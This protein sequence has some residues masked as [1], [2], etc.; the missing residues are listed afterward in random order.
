MPVRKECYDS[1]P[2]D[3]QGKQ[4]GMECGFSYYTSL[5]DGLCSTSSSRRQGG[6]PFLKST[7]EI[8]Q[9]VTVPLQSTVRQDF[10]RT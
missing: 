10:C 7:A 1:M 5:K 2:R 6:S 3:I 4:Q 8:E 9:L